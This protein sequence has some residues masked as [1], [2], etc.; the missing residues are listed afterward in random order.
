EISWKEERNLSLKALTFPFDIYRTGQRKLAVCVYN[1]IKKND[2]LFACAPTGIGK[3]MSTIFPSLKAMGENY[4]D[5]LFYLTAKTVTA[6]ATAQAIEKLNDHYKDLK[7]KTLFITAKD[8][9]CPMEVRQC[10]P[11]ACPYARGYFDKINEVLYWV[12]QCNNVFDRDTVLQIAKSQSLCPYELS[13]DLSLWCDVIVCDYNYLFDPVVKLQ[14]YFSGKSGDY[15]FL[16]DEAHNLPDRAREMYSASID[17]KEFLAIKK[18]IDKKEKRF[19]NSIAKVNSAFLT[20]RHKFDNTQEDKIV[21]STVISEIEKPLTDF[22]KACG[23]FF[24][25]HKGETTDETLLQLYFETKFFLKIFE[26]YDD[27]YVTILSKAEDNV[28]VRLNC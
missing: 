18:L 11:N 26:E 17:K 3:T 22:I 5:K 1:T 10:N 16:I 23:D 28:F 14:R 7:L 27:K 13:L 6:M 25:K 4:G 15:I 12:L 9:I 21:I 20:L 2:R 19:L 24:D 8:K